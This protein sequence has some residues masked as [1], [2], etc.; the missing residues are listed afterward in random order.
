MHAVSP[1]LKKAAL[2][3]SALVAAALLAVAMTP[4][5]FLADTHSRERL[6]QVVPS[7]FGDWQVDRSIVPVPPS[8]DVQQVVDATY[9]ETV[10][11]T[12]RDRQGHRVMLSLAYGR[13]Q[14]K[15]M[16][17]HRPEVC[18]PAQGFKLEQSGQPGQIELQGRALKVTRVVAAMGGRHEP[19][20]YW[21]LVG[22]TITPFGYAQR[23][24]AIRYG[25]QGVIPDGV[26][27]RVSSIERD[28]AEA[29]QLHERFIRDMLGAVG[30]AR[31]PRLI[32]QLAAP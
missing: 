23:W 26:L 22:D 14:H 32:G 12:Y 31:L 27:V 9:D 28:N 15:G 3:A 8:P 25:L 20:T 29:F 6:D 1:E 7:A 10:A 24:T 21:L 4:R 13:N 30:P 18:Y 5:H 17:T 2:L 16:N 11:R 19:I